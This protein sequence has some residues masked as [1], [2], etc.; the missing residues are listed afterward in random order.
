MSNKPIKYVDLFAGI[1]GFAATMVGM[2]F[3]SL[4]AVEKDEAAAD[5]YEDN[6]GG[7]ALGNIVDTSRQDFGNTIAIGPH[8]VL[9]GGFPCQPFSKSGNQDG[10]LDASRGTLFG[11]IVAVLKNLPY[12]SRPTLVIL[13]NV[14]NLAGPK[15]KDDLKKMKAS[16]RLLGYTVEEADIFLSPHQL[17][18]EFGGS[19][20]NRERIFLVGVKHHQGN[21][22]DSSAVVDQYLKS[23]DLN[24]ST[25]LEKKKIDGHPNNYWDITRD[26]VITDSNTSPNLSLSDHEIQVLNVWDQWQ[27]SIRKKGNKLPGFPVWTSYWLDEVTYPANCQAWKK[28]FI[29]K[30]QKLYLE[31]KVACN[32]VLRQIRKNGF[33]PTQS[34]FEWQAGDL[35][36]VFQGVVHFRPSGVRV[37]R[38]TYLPALVAITHTPILAWLKRRISVQEAARLQKFPRNFRFNP[39]KDS[40]S[41]K[42]LGNAV[43]VGVIWQILKALVERDSVLLA[44]SEKGR[45]IAKLVRKAPDDPD[46]FFDSGWKPKADSA[47]VL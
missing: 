45:E 34:K 19:P 18:R 16:L 41:Y 42:Q 5:V 10:V 28:D 4:L 35:E 2:G 36:S 9:T 3:K 47:E 32:E 1:G 31:N 46:V 7:K 40:Q 14:R 26:L 43:C 29:D 37:K 25:I 27:K 24:L 13:E 17:K 8:D 21:E 44:A 12:D 15:H 33:T 11:N 39:D 22:N 38:P 20:Q 23:M 6:W 30:N